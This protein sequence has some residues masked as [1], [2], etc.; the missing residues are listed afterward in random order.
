MAFKNW[1]LSHIGP[2]WLALGSLIAILVLGGLLA[3]SIQ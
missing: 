2:F 1:S 3:V